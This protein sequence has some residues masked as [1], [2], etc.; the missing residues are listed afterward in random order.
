MTNV[1]WQMLN[2]PKQLKVALVCDW[3][4][5]MGGAERVVLELHRM[6][7]EAP[8]YTSS[9]AP[10]RMP[11]FKD[12]DVRTSF[13]QKLPFSD[14]HQ[15]WPVLRR[16][17]FSQLKLTEYDLVI[18]SSGAEAKAV[19]MGAVDGRWQMVDGG[20]KGGAG[21]D[22]RRQTADG[23]NK[24]LHINYCHSPTQYYWVRPEEYM[25][26]KTAGGVGILNPL[27]RLGLKLLKPWM[28]RWDYLAAQNPDYILANSKAVK[29][30]IQKFYNR[31]SEV[32]HPPVE[33]EKFKSS[34]KA[35]V[36]HGFLIVGRQVHHKRF[37]L[38]VKACS[39]LN[40][41][42]KVIGDGPEHKFLR[43]IAGPSVKFLGRIDDSNLVRQ[44]QFAEGFIFP[45][46][47][48]FGIVAVEAMAAG[49]P[50]VAYRAGG[51]LDTVTEGETGLFFAEQTVES[52][53]SALLKFG[54]QTWDYDAI[55]Q[56][57]QVFSTEAF[58]LKLN[59]TIDKLQL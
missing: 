36:R 33:I 42:L 31:D 30:R 41:P 43:S 57:A 21:A 5:T 32:V 23:K 35:S 29:V 6:F 27:W 14:K 50:V 15:L 8:I 34:S 26:A 20:K 7:P 18:S 11:L 55:A 47:D 16:R 40:L 3:L 56:R 37:D 13:I 39:E 12:A 17:Y 44:L 1:K 48:D 46:H 51:A 52:L 22:G 45:Q 58:R 59:K 25:S 10:E 28:K 54:K 24:P 4:T 53:K 2:D 19:N 38:A 49:T 9:F